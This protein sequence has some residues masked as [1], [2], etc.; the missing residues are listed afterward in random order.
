MAKARE[1]FRLEHDDGREGILLQANG[2]MGVGIDMVLE[3]VFLVEQPSHAGH[4]EFA[5]FIVLLREHLDHPVG[6]LRVHPD[7][8]A[9]E[10]LLR[11]AR[12]GLHEEIIAV[13]DT[14]T[15]AV[16]DILLC[17]GRPCAVEPIL[18]EEA[19]RHGIGRQTLLPQC[20]KVDS[21]CRHCGEQQEP[22]CG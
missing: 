22:N 15:G 10:F 12:D 16:V 7:S 20:L 3:G 5:V 21:P 2:L 11:L 4:K 18:E 17:E 9:L 1:D 8:D 14:K 6:L 13:V 19:G